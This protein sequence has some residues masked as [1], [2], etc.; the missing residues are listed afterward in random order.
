MAKLFTLPAGRT[1]KYVVFAVSF[2]LFVGAA[3]QSSKFE[4]AR[5]TRRRRS[6]PAARSR[7]RR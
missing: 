3:S 1:G 5:R 6:C 2:L 7:P 4:K